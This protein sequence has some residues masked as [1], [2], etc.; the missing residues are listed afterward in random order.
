MSSLYY[1][2]AKYCLSTMSAY[3]CK[4]FVYAPRDEA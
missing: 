4:E 1:A 3:R 2:Y